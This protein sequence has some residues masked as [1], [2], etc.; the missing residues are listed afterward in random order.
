MNAT[1]LR[2]FCG[3]GLL[4]TGCS[5]MHI[6]PPANLG[7]PL[8]PAAA[9]SDGLD[10]NV[11]GQLLLYA[12]MAL[13][14]KGAKALPLGDGPFAIEL[15][16]NVGTGFAGVHPAVHWAPAPRPGADWSFGTRLG[17]LVGTGDV[18]GEQPFADPYLGGS[19]H[20]QASRVWDDGGALTT[21]VGWAYTGHT[22]CMGGCSYS[23]PSDDPA[24]PEPDKHSY[25][26][27]HGPILH[28]RADVPAGSEGYA[29]TVGLGAQ[30]LWDG[31]SLLPVFE[32]SAGLHHKD[33][34]PRW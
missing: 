24:D 16:G 29:F 25:L 32:L 5:T 8:P 19:L 3:L 18:L 30:P 28:L 17:A 33:P 13:H 10:V 31:S 9:A 12:P 20:G 22:R 26:P 11:G 2:R 14:L 27:Y 15:G 6:P 23:V 7:A 4:L 34:G 1:T 21:S